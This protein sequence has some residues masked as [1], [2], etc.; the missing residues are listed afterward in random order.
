MLDV[1]EEMGGGVQRI[2]RRTGAGTMNVRGICWGRGGGGTLIDEHALLGWQHWLLLKML[3]IRTRTFQFKLQMFGTPFSHPLRALRKRWSRFWEKLLWHGEIETPF[4]HHSFRHL[5]QTALFPLSGM[6]LSCRHGKTNLATWNTQWRENL[7][8][9]S[10][11]IANFVHACR[12]RHKH[13]H[14]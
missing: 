4:R 1:G 12:Q 3:D 6:I 10:C 2:I 5:S 13:Q 7:L 8:V 9:S 14:T 11:C